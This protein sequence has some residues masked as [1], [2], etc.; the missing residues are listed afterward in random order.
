MRTQV[1]IIGAGPSGLL[2]GQ[3]LHRAGVDAVVLERQTADYV[4]GRIRAGV[5]EQVTVDLLDE[6]GVGERMHREG[7]VHDGFEILVGG[8]RHRVDL[9]GL[10]GG[11][12]V[13]VYGQTEITRDL[14]EARAAQDLPTV[15]EAADVAVHGFDSAKPHVTYREAGR[16]QRLDCD[17][18]A[19]CDGFHGVCR[20]SVPKG[21]IAEYEKVHP[22]GWLGVLSETPPVSDE[23]V[24]VN[25]PRGFALCSMRSRTRSRYYLQVPLTQRLETWTDAAFWR[26]LELRLD[27]PGR[28]RLV[29]GDSIEK[30]I[31]PLRSFVAEP[32][33]FGRLFL[34]GDAGHIVPPTG[35]K[36]LN[37]AATDVKLLASALIEHYEEKSDSGVEHYS[38]RSLRRIWRAERFS[39]WFTALTH[40]FEDETTIGAKLQ[41]AE[42]DYLLHSEAG[43]RTL[44]ENYVGLPLD[45][46][47]NSWS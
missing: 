47:F 15:Y 6:A 4:L 22:F 17:F 7:L 28:E 44:A 24:Y 10:T 27:D 9:T 14:M 36:G 34:A 25:S 35:A 38:D 13:L 8:K 20:A 43:L 31:A 18:I 23:L 26:E 45:F 37:L 5:L 21:A 29:V 33:R 12:H 2:L 19:G 1:A 30:S 16:D 32:L 41:R 40:R 42:L 46:G 3:L 11:K 39:W